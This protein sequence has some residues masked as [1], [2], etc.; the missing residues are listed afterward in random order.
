MEEL[1]IDVEREVQKIREELPAE[2]A[3][4][5]QNIDTLLQLEQKEEDSQIFPGYRLSREEEEQLANLRVKETMARKFSKK[6]DNL[7]Q[8]LRRI[9]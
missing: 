9:R 3:E 1:T 4:F 2:L 5:L 6:L 8:K 7:L